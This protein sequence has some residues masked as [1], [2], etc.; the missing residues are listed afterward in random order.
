[1]YVLVCTSYVTTFWMTV[2]EMALV[3]AIRDRILQCFYIE[4]Q[5]NQILVV[6][7]KLGQRQRL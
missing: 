2:H 1:M 7:D 3:M 5:R 6:T 4:L